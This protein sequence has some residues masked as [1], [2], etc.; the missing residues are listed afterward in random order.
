MET[1]AIEQ[2]YKLLYEFTSQATCNCLC[3]L[4]KILPPST[5]PT[6]RLSTIIKDKGKFEQLMNV[7]LNTCWKSYHEKT[8]EFVM[9]YIDGIKELNTFCH[10][11]CIFSLFTAFICELHSTLEMS[12]DKYPIFEKAIDP[13]GNVELLKQNLGT[14]LNDIATNSTK[15]K[16]ADETP[17]H[18]CGSGCEEVPYVND[19]MPDFF[20]N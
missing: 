16:L 11:S 10:T 7:Y 6:R 2:T 12:L 15:M 3:A 17:L 19:K 9:T 8:D 18:G 4:Y 5:D 13:I 20:K 14:L 1:S